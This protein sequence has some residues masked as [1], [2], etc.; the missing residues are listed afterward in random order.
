MN[1]LD[2]KDP[3]KIKAAGETIKKFREFASNFSKSDPFYLNAC[4][5]AEAMYAAKTGNVLDGSTAPKD[6]IEKAKNFK[7]SLHKFADN[8]EKGFDKAG[9]EQTVSNSTEAHSSNV[10][11]GAADAADFE[12][13]GDAASEETAEK[14]FK[15]M[16]NAVKNG[17]VPLD[18][19]GRVFNYM[20]MSKRIKHLDDIFD[21]GKISPDELKQLETFKAS[22]NDYQDWAVDHADS[23]DP[24]IQQQVAL[25]KRATAKFN[26]MIADNKDFLHDVDSSRLGGDPNSAKAMVGNEE[27]K[28]ELQ[29]KS[30]ITMFTAL[31]WA[32]LAA[33][34]TGYILN[35][36]KTIVDVLGA[37]AIKKE[38]DKYIVASMSALLSNSKDNKSKMSDT[39]FSVRYSLKD[40]KW[41]ATC[42]D[43]R[44]MDFPE[45]EIIDL[46]LDSEIGKKFK[47]A[48][49]S[50][51]S[52]IFDSDAKNS[53]VV[54]FVLDNF[55]KI[56]L[57]ANGNTKKILDTVK[58][59][60]ENFD[61]IKSNFK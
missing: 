18:S 28:E 45:K 27:M 34:T 35:H 42:I 7:G 51:W 11:T 33:K 16:E 10:Q 19:K 55:E 52:K 56:G 9:I 57:K 6:L 47:E 38:E 1:N 43:N 5:G 37:Q 13:K 50:K 20:N 49:I 39:K 23:T 36:G 58:T 46:M 31:G 17:L 24:K 30:G 22:L 29:K 26:N 59:M 40:F 48:C 54:K 60:S 12:G 15:R 44:K 2:S 61:K 4:K 8:M 14:T 32:R 41:H 3:E 53:G 25:I 21:D